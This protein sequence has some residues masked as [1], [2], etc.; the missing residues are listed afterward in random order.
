MVIYGWNSKED[1]FLHYFPKIS[2]EN[3]VAWPKPRWPILKYSRHCV[4]SISICLYITWTLVIN[5]LSSSR[6]RSLTP[7][8]Y[9]VRRTLFQ[10]QSSKNKLG[11]LH[12]DTG[13]QHFA[14]VMGYWLL[15]HEHV[16]LFFCFCFLL[17]F[18]KKINTYLDVSRFKHSS[19]G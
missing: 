12:Q 2:S 5:I 8:A 18:F 14:E 4:F 15:F 13:T 1:I 3:Q 19:S 6:K 10:R 9:F 16:L 7:Y 11:D 17:F